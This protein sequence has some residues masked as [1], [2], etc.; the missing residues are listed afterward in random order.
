MTRTSQVSDRVPFQSACTVAVPAPAPVIRPAAS[1]VAT[2][3]SLVIHLTWLEESARL[4][5]EYAAMALSWA[6]SPVATSTSRGSTVKPTSWASVTLTV[7]SFETTP[8]IFAV[9]LASPTAAPVMTPSESRLLLAVATPSLV[10]DQ[11][12]RCVMS[13]ELRSSNRP[14]AVSCASVPTGTTI[15]SGWSRMPMGA[16]SSPESSLLRPLQP[17][18]ARIKKRRAAE[19]TL[20]FWNIPDGKPVSNITAIPFTCAQRPRQ[21][22]RSA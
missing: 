18:M 15:C 16:S 17:Q 9:T 8:E 2:P 6:T 12:T 13:R 3:P 20:P 19:A 1:T 21:G 7:T 11:F 10:E 14:M 22:C 4:P 5:S